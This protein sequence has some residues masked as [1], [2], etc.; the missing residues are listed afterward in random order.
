MVGT[1]HRPPSRPP[2]HVTYLD[3][4]AACNRHDLSRYVPFSVAGAS[5]GWLRRDRFGWLRQN[6]PSLRVSDDEVALD[7]DL[8]TFESR[9][10]AMGDVVESLVTVGEVI[11]W[12]SELYP[13]GTSF[14]AEPLLQIERVAVPYF[15]I[16]AYGIHINGFVRKSDELQMWIARRARDKP[17][18]PGKLDNI[19][20]GGQPIG[21]TLHDNLVKEC[22]EEAS[23]PPE[24]AQQ[25]RPIGGVT[26]C[27]ETER[28]LKPDGLFCYD[29]EL[30]ADFEPRAADGEV[31]SFELWPLARVAE[32][33]RDTEEF[34]LNCNLVV[35]DFLIRHG[36]IPA[37]DP[38]YLEIVRGLRSWGG[39]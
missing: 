18:Y 13:V 3:R 21:I 26:Y 36:A 20:A 5:V 2:D 16:S 14:A 17:T 27:F 28:G 25:A 24:L 32:V 7:P 23:I 9:S 30:P 22:A 37:D 8:S 38:D 4:I 1:D 6:A 34:K 33:V 19:V 11:P 39:H 10:N 31:E 35:I 29:L 12:H 15:G